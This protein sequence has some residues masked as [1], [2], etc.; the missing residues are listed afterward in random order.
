M[1]VG[2][3]WLGAQHPAVLCLPL[4]VAIHHARLPNPFL[5]EVES[6]LASGVLAVAIASPTLAQGLNLNAAVLLVPSL[7][8]A[9]ILLTGEEFANVAGRAGRAFVDLDGLVLHVMYKPEQ[10]RV[11]QWAE[12]VNSA[13]ARSLSSGI[14][15]VVNE[16]MKRLARTGV[17]SRDDALEYLA[18]S[19]D[20]WFPPNRPEDTETMASL[21]ERLDA[22]V[23]GL[24]EALDANSDELPAL[25]DAALTGSLWSRQIARLAAESRGHQLWIMEARARLI[26]NKSTPE[27]RRSQFAMGVGLESGLALDAIAAELTNHLDAADLA[28]TAGN[29]S[30]LGT[31]SLLWPSA[32]FRSRRSF[33]IQSCL[34]NGAMFCVHG[35][36]GRM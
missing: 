30:E 7:H 27:Q 14:I 24:V 11:R 9:G 23:L 12:L 15:T 29:A 35:L 5:R 32:F 28:A 8:R 1:A 13:K 3:E 34:I 26:W 4:G 6:L 22:T 21:V 19:Q 31:L 25:L 18:N 20:A 33:L 36:A 10:W 17:F 16:V 2:R